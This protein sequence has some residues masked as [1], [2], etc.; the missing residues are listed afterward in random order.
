MKQLS[1]AL[2]LPALT[3]I[4]L[5]TGLFSCDPAIPITLSDC[6]PCP[7]NTSCLDGD[8]GCP[9]DRVDMGSWC[10]E[11]R[12]NLFVAASLECPCIQVLGLYLLDINAEAGNGSLPVSNYCLVG[13]G[14]PQINNQNS[15]TYYQRPDGD[16]IAI[17]NIPIPDYG[18]NDNCLINDSLYCKIDMFGKFK[19]PDTI[20][21]TVRWRRCLT[22]AGAGSNFQKT[23]HL[24]FVRV[25]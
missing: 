9:A 15:F 5:L 4:L 2:L 7:N 1:T 14:N 6:P 10:L 20:Q 8:C 16:S 11:K 3:A 19:G 13:P 25:K 23:N 24:T 18:G 21:T 17:Y 22:F 12:E